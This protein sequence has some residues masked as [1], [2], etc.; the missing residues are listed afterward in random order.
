[1]SS[2]VLDTLRRVVCD[3]AAYQNGEPVPLDVIKSFLIALE[4]IYHELL[5]KGSISELTSGER[6]AR[7]L[8]R[9][10]VAVLLNLL[11]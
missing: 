5:I 10:S 7:E 3:L 1:M 11:T 4:R 2:W 8:I 6:E 9:N